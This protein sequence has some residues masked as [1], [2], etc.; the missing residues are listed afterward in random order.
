MKAYHIIQWAAEHE[1][2]ESRKYK[3]LKWTP[4]PNKHE[5]LGYRMI[6][7]SPLRDSLYAGWKLICEVSSKNPG[8]DRGWLVRDGRA[9]TAGDL[10]M[11]TGFTEKT[12]K[13]TLDFVCKKEVG[14][15]ELADYPPIAEPVPV[16]PG[17]SPGTPEGSP[18]VPG[19]SPGT[20]L[21]DQIRSEKT[22][23]SPEERER[24]AGFSTPEGEAKAQLQ[25]F[26]AAQAR[27]RELEALTEELTDEQEEELKK[28]RRLVKAIQKK[29]RAGDFRPLKEDK[30]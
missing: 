23:I 2:A 8:D 19:E 24:R 10:A 25:Q 6:A 1:T 14:W 5:G 9:M 29:Q 11:I 3:K 16:V 30:P 20:P 15:L 17:E 18:V 13:L 4:M 7:R 26:A 22:R 21:I 27:K 28:M 12:F